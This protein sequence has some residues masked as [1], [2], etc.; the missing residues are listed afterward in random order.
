MST[1]EPGA[2][3]APEHVREESVGQLLGEL[4]SDLSTLVRQEIALAKAEVT[5]KAKEA[6]VG[7]GLLGGAGVIGLAALGALTAFLIL[8]L[9]L[10]MAAWLAALIVTIVWAVVAGILALAGRQRL[11]RATPPTPE[12]AIDST[13]EDVQ[14]A[15]TQLRSEKR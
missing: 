6:G 12:Q 5:G 15:K 2:Q 11:Q 8:L 4:S 10:W 14:W 1:P 9:A 13:K 7:A 3:R